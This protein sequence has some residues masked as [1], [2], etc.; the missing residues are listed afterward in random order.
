[1]SGNPP[2]PGPS[3]APDDL[4]KHITR[5]KAVVAILDILAS[6]DDEARKIILTGVLG[7]IDEHFAGLIGQRMARGDRS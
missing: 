7:A 4:P 3:G 5:M 2:R 6:F 1:M